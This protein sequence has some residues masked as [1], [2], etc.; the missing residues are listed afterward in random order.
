MDLDEELPRLAE[1]PCAECDLA[2][3][4]LHLARDEYADLDLAEP[5]SLLN[6]WGCA[7]KGRICQATLSEK[8][9]RCS[10]ILGLPYEMDR[11]LR[12]GFIWTTGEC[13]ADLFG[14]T[15]GLN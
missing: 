2:G 12:L 11:N 8:V 3:V 7:L 5:V 14:T 13:P 9:E 10:K 15:L 6:R 4:A 1:A